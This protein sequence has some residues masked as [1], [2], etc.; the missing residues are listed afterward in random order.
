MPITQHSPGSALQPPIPVVGPYVHPCPLP[1]VT[2]FDVVA[3]DHDNAYICPCQGPQIIGDTV[4]SGYAGNVYRAIHSE[5]GE[6]VAVKQLRLRHEG[7]AP[8]RPAR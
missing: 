5:S 6:F 1:C 7:S 2:T 3:Q 8:V 4:G